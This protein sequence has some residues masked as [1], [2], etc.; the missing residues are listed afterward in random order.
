MKHSLLLV[1]TFCAAVAGNTLKAQINKT[2]RGEGPLVTQDRN[3]GSFNEIYTHGSFDI[4]ITDGSSNSVK[5]ETQANLQEYIEIETKGSELHI[6]NKKGYNIK[7]DKETVIHITAPALKGIYL[8]GSG[9]INTTNQLTG[10]DEFDIKSSGSGNLTLDI[11]T[12]SLECAIS[13]SGNITLKG[14][15]NEFEGKI[16]GSGNIRAKEMQSAIT[17]V[18]ISGSG[19]A[20]VVATEKLDTKIAGSGDVKYWG[21]AAVTSKVAGSGSVSRQK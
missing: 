20:Q 8:A 21:D 9:N 17:S 1:L 6:R 12:K 4:D 14:K 7:G 3:V 13:G 16:S 5:V 18:K 11:E 19:S 2:I 10:S 15:T